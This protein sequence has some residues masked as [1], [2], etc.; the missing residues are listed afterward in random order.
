MIQ[1]RDDWR[2]WQDA[3]RFNCD[4]E[5][6]KVWSNPHDPT[7]FQISTGRGEIENA[8][9]EHFRSRLEDTSECSVFSGIAEP[10]PD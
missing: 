7:C 5:S 4:N 6:R 10:F 3:N 1:R 2:P 9:G 8:S